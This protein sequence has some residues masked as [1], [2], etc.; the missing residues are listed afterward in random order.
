MSNV[1]FEE[2]WVALQTVKKLMVNFFPTW[3]SN[4]DIARQFDI[5]G[6]YFLAKKVEKE[7]A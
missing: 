2:A 3:E 5:L 6:N 4:E 7:N 1:T